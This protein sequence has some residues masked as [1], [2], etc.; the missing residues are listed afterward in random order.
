MLGKF[1]SFFHRILIIVFL[2][3]LGGMPDPLTTQPSEALDIRKA[4]SGIIL[5]LLPGEEIQS[6]QKTFR[7]LNIT[8]YK[9]LW[10]SLPDDQSG[11][12]LKKWTRKMSESCKLNR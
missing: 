11:L 9:A 4:A 7:A 2:A 3:N 1:R 12:A 5:K 8:G 10:S 6:L